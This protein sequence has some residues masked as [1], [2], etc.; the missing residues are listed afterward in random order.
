MAHG[1]D[2]TVGHTGGLHGIHEWVPKIRGV[3]L[4]VKGC[5]LDPTPLGV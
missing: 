1:A 3:G 4:G 5:R 2:G